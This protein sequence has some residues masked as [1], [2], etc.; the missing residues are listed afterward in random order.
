MVPM[1]GHDTID[2]KVM[3]VING[4]TVIYTSMMNTCNCKYVR[5][6]ALMTL[7]KSFL[8]AGLAGCFALAPTIRA[9]LDDRTYFQVV[10][11]QPQV[12]DLVFIRIGGPLFSRVAQTTE[13]WTSHVGII[14]DQ[15]NGDWVVAESGIPFVRLTPL[16]RFLDRSSGQKFSLRRLKTPPS[17]E[18]KRMMRRIAEAQLGKL[19]SLGFDLESQNTFCSKFVR[20]VVYQATRQQVGEVETFDH[21]LHRN[22]EAPLWFWRAW[23]FGSIPWRRMTVTPASELDSPLLRVVAEN[24]T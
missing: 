20:D 8:L 21:L 16:R 22:P 3:R 4:K 13:S 24:N 12:G 23:F 14:V 19:Y 15:A 1:D 7:R 17:D 18:E 5:Y 9:T 6:C 11:S 10:A 2:K